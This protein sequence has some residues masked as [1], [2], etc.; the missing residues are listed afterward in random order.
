MK[1]Y[2][3]TPFLLCALYALVNLSGGGNPSAG[4]ASVFSSSDACGTCHQDIFRE[5]SN[6][7][8]AASN[9]DPVFRGVFERTRK[10]DRKYCISCHAPLLLLEG[11]TD[12]KF[13]P[14]VEGITCDYCH[15]VKA[16]RVGK[17][18]PYE[19]ALDKV[20]RGP[21]ETTETTGHSSAYSELHTKSEF[22]A[23]CHEAVNPL[24]VAV[25]DTFEEWK[26]GPYPDNDIHCQNCHM[27]TEFSSSVVTMADYRSNRPVTAHRFLGGHSQI[28]ITTAAKMSMLLDSNKNQVTAVVY[29]TNAE[30]G[31]RLPTGIPARRV[32]LEVRVLN[33]R[34][35]VL[36]TQTVEYRRVLQDAAG[37]EIPADKIED[38]FS[39]AAAVKSDNRIAPKETRREQFVFPIADT[40]DDRVVVEASMYYLFQVPFLLPNVMRMPMAHDI[41]IA[42][43]PRAHSS[44]K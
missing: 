40:S 30:S 2:Y 39:K 5:W 13:P 32:V 7:L 8:H 38:M 24:G 11:A 10:Q 20:K 41:Q 34:G 6:S 29:V 15:R 17:S 43:L 23:G 16:V 25:L 27:P 36:A 28:N 3:L 14:T 21:F 37:I 4:Q 18:P 1:A 9:S 22:C 19:L 26:A 35:K 42:R 44:P 33:S 12:F 31:H